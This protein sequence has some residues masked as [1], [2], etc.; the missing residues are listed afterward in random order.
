MALTKLNEVRHQ[1]RGQRDRI[2]EYRRQRMMW[3]QAELQASV[4]PRMFEQWCGVICD[5]QQLM[6]GV[7]LQ[8]VFSAKQDEMGN[9]MNQARMLAEERERVHMSHRSERLTSSSQLL[10]SRSPSCNRCS[11]R[12]HGSGKSSKPSAKSWTLTLS[13]SC[14]CAVRCR[15]SRRSPCGHA[16]YLLGRDAAMMYRGI[17]PATSRRA[18]LTSRGSSRESAAAPPAGED[19]DLRRRLQDMRERMLQ[20]KA[21]MQ[22]A[23][24]KMLTLKQAFKR[25]EVRPA[26][27]RTLYAATPRRHHRLPCA[28]AAGAVGIDECGGRG[29]CVRGGRRPVVPLVWL[30]SSAL[31]GRLS[32]PATRLT[33]AAAWYAKSINVEL[34][35]VM[36]QVEKLRAETE[37]CRATLQQ[38]STARNSLEGELVARLNQYEGHASHMSPAAR[39]RR[40]TH[41]PLPPTESKHGA[42]PTNSESQISVH[43]SR[44]WRRVCSR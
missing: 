15:E 4:V 30:H 28:A 11:S 3:E 39:R 42:R 2:N 10:G 37:A 22:H 16:A 34:E 19:G 1:E 20:D 21:A 25:L 44:S 43:S 23:Q 7:Q 36:R 31:S 18:G 8:T 6:R 9:M 17:T 12:Q 33:A 35:A 29:G 14:R 41:K 13:L 5:A 38:E 27:A 40:A 24:Q 26:C 32:P